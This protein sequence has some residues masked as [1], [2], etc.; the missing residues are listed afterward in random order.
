MSLKTILKD[1]IS[2]MHP[3]DIALSGIII[4]A[5]ILPSIVIIIGCILYKIIF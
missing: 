5:V 2:N 4:A 1:K 3:V